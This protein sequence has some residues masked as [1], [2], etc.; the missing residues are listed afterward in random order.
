MLDTEETSQFLKQNLFKLQSSLLTNPYLQLSRGDEGLKEEMY[1]VF[2]QGSFYSQDLSLHRGEHSEG[3]KKHETILHGGSS[4]NLGWLVM[5]LSQLNVC[6]QRAGFL[7]PSSIY[8]WGKYG[9]SG[10]TLNSSL[11]CRQ[12]KGERLSK[13]KKVYIYENSA[14]SLNCGLESSKFF[15][16]FLKLTF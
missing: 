12:L 9:G 15:Q 7:F 1:T 4:L 11:S 2:Y 5:R 13:W 14:P 16:A 3:P 10:Q 6:S 8:D